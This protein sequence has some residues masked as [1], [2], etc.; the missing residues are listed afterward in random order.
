MLQ[1][2]NVKAKVQEVC[3]VLRKADALFNNSVIVFATIL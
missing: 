2:V 1:L 3:N